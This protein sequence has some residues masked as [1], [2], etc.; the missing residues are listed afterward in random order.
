MESP[1]DWFE[2][3]FIAGE[4]GCDAVFV[5]DRG[6]EFCNE[7]G[8]P[9]QGDSQFPKA[10]WWQSLLVLAVVAVGAV[11]VGS[12]RLRTPAAVER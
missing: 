7:T 5:D 2:R 3:L 11:V 10:F 9:I 6:Q 1:F 8:E 4:R 12:H